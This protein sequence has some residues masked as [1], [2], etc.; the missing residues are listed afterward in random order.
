MLYYLTQGYFVYPLAKQRFAQKRQCCKVAS[1]RLF[2]A[3]NNNAQ[4]L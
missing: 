3:K 4:F 1:I 2:L